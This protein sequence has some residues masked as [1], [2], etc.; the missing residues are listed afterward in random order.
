[1][2]RSLQI[3][4][5]NM[6]TSEAVEARIRQNLEKL[7]KS[8]DTLLGCRVVVEAP[9]AHQQKGGL[10][11]TRI[12]LTLPAGTIVV[13]REPD[14]HKGSTDVYVSIRDAFAAAERQLQKLSK[15]RQGEV[16]THEHQSQGHISELFP[17]MDYGRIITTVGDDIYFN[18]NSVLNADF[19]ALKVGIR[20]SF[21]EEQGD[22]GPQASSV[23]VLDTDKA[24][25]ITDAT[26]KE[27]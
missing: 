20:V 15:R 22:E 1:M 17:Q 5:R 12:D 8:C 3:T 16:K 26:G 21:V 23:K 10:Y 14:L 7:E 11:H 19:D 18:R 4:F 2:Q 27:S 25:R 24:G 6:K 13:N 9:H